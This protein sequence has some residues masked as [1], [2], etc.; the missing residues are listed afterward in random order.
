MTDY[1][2]ADLAVKEAIILIKLKIWKSC[3]FQ[4][5]KTLSDKTMGNGMKRKQKTNNQ[6]CAL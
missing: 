5:N 6:L 3:A 1:K 4:V 2:K